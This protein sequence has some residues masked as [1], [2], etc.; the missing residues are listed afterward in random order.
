MSKALVISSS[1]GRRYDYAPNEQITFMLSGADTS[2]QLDLVESEFGY[3]GGLPLHIHPQQNEIHYILEGQ[4]RYQI[5]K[6]TF[7]TKS[8]DCVYIPKD[9]PHAWIN[10]QQEP[11]R[12]IGILTPGG[13]EGFFQTLSSLPAEQTDSESL[14]KLAED[15]GAEIV[16]P[17]L[18]ISLGL[19]ENN[20]R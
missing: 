7:E 4:L 1:K 6:E 13:S 15:Y 8:G 12:I 2:G 11:A 14:T 16:G 10:L 17:P 18:A 20:V 9:T 19:V 3:L 5:G